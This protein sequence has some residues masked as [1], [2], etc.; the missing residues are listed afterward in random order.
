MR[1][2]QRGFSLVETMFVVG[3]SAVVAGVILAVSMTAGR[4]VAINRAQV[5]STQEARRGL[6]E[7]V[8]EVIRA[9]VAEVTDETGSS[10]WPPA[11]SWSGLQFRYPE[12]VDSAGNVDDWSATVTYTLDEDEQQLVRT[13]SDGNSRVVANGVT[14]LTI[15]EGDVPE[16]MWIQLT[17][18]RTSTTGHEI[19]QP[20]GVRVRVR[21]E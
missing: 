9:P 2:G 14:A 12:T 11:S 5:S 17:T 10:A 21:N 13:D 8:R 4:S 18:A 1:T 16:E 15:Q 20:L 3:I 19:Q 6:E 7:M